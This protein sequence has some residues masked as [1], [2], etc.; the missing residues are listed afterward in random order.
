[1]FRSAHDAEAGTDI[2]TQAAATA[3]R[4]GSARWEQEYRLEEL[5][6]EISTLRGI[7]VDHLATF[8]TEETTALSD[9]DR[10][11]ISK[12]LHRCLDNLAWRSTQQY[13]ALQQSALKEANLAQLQI[14]R[15]VSHELRNTLNSLSLAADFT[16]ELTEPGSRYMRESLDRNVMEMRE[17]LEDLLDLSALFSEGPTLDVVSFSA[18]TALSTIGIQYRPLAEA[19]GLT[20]IINLSESLGFVRCDILK[21]QK[22]ASKLLSNAIR[23]T[24]SGYISLGSQIVNHEQWA[25]LV[26]DTGSGIAPEHHRS[27]LADDYRIENVSPIRGIGFTIPLVARLVVLLDG[28]FF[29]E[30]PEGHRNR[31]RIILPR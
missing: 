13:V 29:L 31:F 20:L 4:H 21:L 28:E 25:L 18:K 17:M 22:I 8:E 14:L 12:I 15:G 24:D 6:V 5:V 30:S 16:D 1:M 23:Y 3:Q 2:S 11:A 27:I 9:R 26:E 10:S 7:L 19:K